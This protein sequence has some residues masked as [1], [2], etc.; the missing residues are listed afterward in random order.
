M[1]KRVLI[2]GLVLATVAAA[3][4]AAYAQDF[5]GRDR[6]ERGRE[7]VME[8]AGNQP[9]DGRVTFVR[10]RYTT[11]FG[12][13]GRRGSR[14]E[15]P[16]AHDYPIADTHVMKIINELTLLRPRIDGSNVYSFSDPELHNYPIAY[17]SE[18]GAWTMDDEE[19]AGLRKYLL[20]GGFVIFD[21]FR[22]PD[23]YNLEEQMRRAI[24]EGYWV[25]LDA[26]H[27][28][29]HSFFEI[30]DLSYLPSYSPYAMPSY[31]GMFED[32]DRNKRLIALANR[33]NDLGEY[34][35]FSDTGYAPVDLS[36]QA[37]KFGVNYFM[38]GLTH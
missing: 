4:A 12:G 6:R 24:P 29:F 28:I 32:N 3:V 33:D 22:G 13:F 26:S 18:P 38:Y 8:I 17:V 5:F 25:E 23:W 1:V 21:D 30:D 7:E 35:E 9:Y 15:L 27:P 16:W 36:N 34:W 31:W 2:P 14:G 20:K 37:Y 11:G 10:I 19:A